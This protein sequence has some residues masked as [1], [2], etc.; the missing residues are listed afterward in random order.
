MVASSEIRLDVISHNGSDS[1]ILK[2]Q[3]RVR[4]PGPTRTTYFPACAGNVLEFCELD[5]TEVIS[6]PRG[7]P[8]TI[9]RRGEARDVCMEGARGTGS[10]ATIAIIV[11][12]RD[13]RWKVSLQRDL[14]GE[15]L[16]MP[17]SGKMA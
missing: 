15:Y 6:A 13:A 1:P 12:D 8:C 2:M 16:Y 10:S 3:V 9:V 5:E 4:L 11:V 7:D 14:H 17:R